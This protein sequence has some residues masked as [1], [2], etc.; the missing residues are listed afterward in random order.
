MLETSSKPHYGYYGLGFF[1]LFLIVIVLVGIA[2]ALWL[3]LP[4]GLFIIA[5]G[6]AL[7]LNYGVSMYLL[8][9]SKSLNPPPMLGLEGDEMVLDVGCGLGKMTVGIAKQLKTGKVIGIDIWSKAEI[10]GNSAKRAM[11]NA[12]IEGVADRTEFRTG[13]VLAIPFN[14]ES[15]DIVASVSVINNLH[16]DEDKLKALK[17]IYR[18][19]RSGGKFLLLEPLRDL[20]GAFVFTPLFIWM[21]SPKDKWVK[22][23]ENAGFENLE[24]GRLNKMGAFLVKKKTRETPN[25]QQH[26]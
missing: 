26:T 11:E 1:A 12:R 25:N 2:A 9:Q 8:G 21:A 14:D 22:L 3:W 4:L 20:Q 18:V 6:V 15:F 17:E 19:L 16:N 7:L 13:N 10:P 24:Y 23:L 5:A